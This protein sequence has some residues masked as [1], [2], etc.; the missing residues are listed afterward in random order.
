MYELT[1]EGYAEMMDSEIHLPIY[2]EV[3]GRLQEGIANTPGTLLYTAC[4]SGH[5][6]EMFR[7]QYDPGRSL[8]GIDLSPHGD[9]LTKATWQRRQNNGR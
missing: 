6:L 4:G 3:L 7:S 1:A 2:R 5:M 9:H 8:M